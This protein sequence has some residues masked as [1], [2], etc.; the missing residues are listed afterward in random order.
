MIW[1][2]RTLSEHRERVDHSK[3]DVPVAQDVSIDSFSVSRGIEDS[4]EIT[5][6][7]PKESREQLY[8]T[9]FYIPGTAFV[10]REKSFTKVVCS[11]LA[12]ASASQV[13][14]LTHRLAP[15]VQIQDM[16]D[17][18]LYGLTKC[19]S[20]SDALKIDLRRVTLSGYSS[21]G[22]LAIQLM[23]AA[24]KQGLGITKHVLF[25]P[26]ADLSRATK[27]FEL[28]EKKDEAIS[29]EFVRWFLRHTFTSAQADRRATYVSPFWHSRNEFEGLAPTDLIFGEFDR[30]RG[31]SEGLVHKLSNVGVSVDR[32]MVKD[33]DH[34]YLWYKLSVIYLV[35]Q[36]LR[37]QLGIER[38]P[39]LKSYL[40]VTEPESEVVEDITSLNRRACL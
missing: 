10:A 16:F 17:D 13:L 36:R 19:L 1:E 14:V 5:L 3:P 30:F 8:P 22:N 18:L 21:G 40:I 32:L 26:L 31:D 20:S 25:S 34:S 28:F 38:V 6:F 23:L 9:L 24:N 37:A 27:G 2:H 7:R 39:R 4:L 33:A 35:G 15:E 12:L 11:H 29:E